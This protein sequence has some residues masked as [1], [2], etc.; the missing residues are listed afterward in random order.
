[1]VRKL[2][3]AGIA[4]VITTGPMIGIVANP[5]GADPT[6][7]GEV[8]TLD[9]DGLGTL[10][11]ATNGNGLWTPGLVIDGNQVLIPYRFRFEFTPIGGDTEVF[12]VSKPAPRNGRLD[13][14]TFSGE[15]EGGTFFG[16]VWI[17]YTPTE[18]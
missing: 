14:C 7:P 5:A 3:G 4:L 9:C 13:V 12:E 10:E 6:N 2:I 8:L 1:M 11:I 17:S 16:T 18:A 15:E